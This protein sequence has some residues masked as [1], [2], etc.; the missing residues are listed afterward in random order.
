MN[1]VFKITLA[2][3]LIMSAASTA[4]AES[5]GTITFTGLIINDTCD[6]KIEGG[7]NNYTVAFLPTYPEDYNGDGAEGT[8]KEFTMQLLGCEPGTLTGVNAAFTGTT[9]DA[10]KEILNVTSTQS[11]DRNVGI[12]LYSAHNNGGEKAVKFDGSRPDDADFAAF[13]NDGKGKKD[14]ALKYTAKVIQTGANKPTAGDYS[15]S[16]TY[17]LV[18][19]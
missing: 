17:E 4:Q 16:A 19:N 7:S 10:A 14:A 3:A 6:I 18:Y 2:A 11:G 12:R 9:L 1:N 15:A 8:T 13:A 5:K